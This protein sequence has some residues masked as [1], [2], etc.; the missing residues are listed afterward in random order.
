MG[1]LTLD[2][3]VRLSVTRD[4]W[5]SNVGKEADGS[6]GGAARLKIKSN[7]EMSVIDIDPKPLAS[8][9]VRKA[10]L[11]LKLAGDAPPR[12]VTVGTFGAE[13]IEGTA[14]NYELQDGSSTHNRR[15]H[16]DT[17]WT[18]PGGDLCSVILGQGGTI[19][20]NADA[21]P[22]GKDGWQT[23]DVDPRVVMAR[24]AGVS[25][26]FIIFD[27][28]GSEW[29]RDGEK[30]TY[31]L[32]PNRYVYSRDQNAAS[33]PYFTVEL[34]DADNA[35]PAAP[36][37]LKSS[38]ADLPA[39]EAWITW[40][41]P[42]DAG[43]S[44]TIGFF[45]RVDG[46][47]V[48]RYLIP[49]AGKPGSI[50]R[51]HLRDL[52]LKPGA[53]VGCE[54]EAVDGAGNRGRAA[55][56][57]VRVSDRLPLKLPGADPSSFAGAGA[58]PKLGV[59]DVAVIDELDKID[60]L[61]QAV[62]P[63]QPPGYLAANH[64]WD[65]SHRLIRLHAARNEIVAFQVVIKGPAKHVQAEL[66]FAGAQA[67]SIQTSFGRY[68]QVKTE[69]GWMPDPIVS[70]AGKDNDVPFEFPSSSLH[71]EVLVPQ[72]LNPG[73]HV[74][75]LALTL[76]AETL[77]LNV[78]L[79]VWNFAL[80]N[81]LSFLAEM[82]AYDLPAGEREFYRLAHGHR[83]VLN[84][85]PYY[86]N[87]RLSDG[88]APRWDGKSLD[89]REW[90]RRFGP[91][92]DGS[93]FAGLPRE[94]VPIECFYLP[95]HE[96]WPTPIDPNYNG[97]LWADRA[98]TPAYRAAL[99]E[100]TRQFAEHLGAKGYNRTRFQLFLNNKVDF[101]R[102]GWSRGSSPWLLDEPANLHDFWALRWFGLAF[103]DGLRQAK[104]NGARLDYR[105]DISRPQWQRDTLDGLLTY[106]V[107]SSALRQYH[108]IVF[109]RA[110][111]FHQTVL[112]Y[113]STNSIDASNLQPVGWMLDAWSLGCDGVVPWQTIG[114]PRSWAKADEL[115]LLYPPLHGSVPIP[116][117]RLKAYRRG[118][119]DVEYLALLAQKLAAPRWAV[120]QAL[121]AQLPI[122]GQRSGTGFTGGED[123]G[124]MDYAKLRPQDLW[125]LR[126]RIG[127]W[128]S[129]NAK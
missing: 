6:N 5:F 121:R 109:D 107:C 86:Q 21:S 125:T 85:L 61:K 93:A 49:A 66:A 70:I 47:D 123:A 83:T 7:Q 17:A 65:A 108:R 11:H 16:P 84:R 74:G 8:R 90:D 44:G 80:P 35:P 13:W 116:S 52:E 29:T 53:N 33:A 124:R 45:V 50:A 10:A 57:N 119:Q 63:P 75:L 62:I 26:G 98:F 91:L 27:D 120:G 34:G 19:W 87:G 76:G 71:V 43:G 100:V 2:E 89:W 82:N 31:H 103:Q 22:P 72:N 114:T 73:K 113:G 4:T 39:G 104:T 99:V 48:P 14:T 9:G 95:L 122:T 68:R 96:N 64:L 102:N 111:Q 88:G 54:V 97:D 25:H 32:F 58:L 46:K 112:E 18:A 42:S 37:N 23:I 106:N 1:V 77:E 92:L 101:K 110:E 69:H 94:G 67:Q 118:E 28:T 56:A 55:S 129:Q 51:M 24:A 126:A 12:R 105:C 79:N 38:A 40:E 15:V 78:E 127:E 128:L 36:A 41:T 115:S 59:H 60:P 117:V 30:F 20:R 81:A 3:P